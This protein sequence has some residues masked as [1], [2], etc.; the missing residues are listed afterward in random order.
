MTESPSV[1]AKR[2]AYSS[3]CAIRTCAGTFTCT[4]SKRW[5]SIALLLALAL[6]VAIT[7]AARI[8]IFFIINI[9]FKTFFTSFFCYELSIS[10]EFRRKGT[11][12]FLF[13]GGMFPYSVGENPYRLFLKKNH[14]VNYFTEKGLQK[15]FINE[16]D[17]I[18]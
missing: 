2:T 6:M 14:R 13:F 12:T 8:I 18:H 1:L 11:P 3:P 4:L 9:F 10:L 7:A 16:I 5:V 17:A 15:P